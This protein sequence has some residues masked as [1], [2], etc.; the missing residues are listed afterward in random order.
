MRKDMYTGG[1]RGGFIYLR[2]AEYV[3]S[4][5]YKTDIKLPMLYKKCVWFANRLYNVILDNQSESVRGYAGRFVSAG[6]KMSVVESLHKDGG[7]LFDYIVNFKRYDAI[8]NKPF[9]VELLENVIKHPPLYEMLDLSEEVLGFEISNGTVSYINSM[10]NLI[11][12]NTK[13]AFMNNKEL[14]D[15]IKINSYEEVIETSEKLFNELDITSAFKHLSLILYKN[16][17]R[18]FKFINPIQAGEYVM[19]LLEKLNKSGQKFQDVR[20]YSGILDIIS[21]GSLGY[22]ILHPND[23][24]EYLNR[25]KKNEYY[26]FDLDKYRIIRDICG[27][28]D[29]DK[30]V[31]MDIPMNRNLPFYM[32]EKIWSYYENYK[33]PSIQTYDLI[34]HYFEK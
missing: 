8:L 4:G 33:V 7:R 30:Y 29:K 11:S 3:K 6:I 21:K 16:K 24:R 23:V 2:M 9:L 15:S 12:N 27:L 34:K 18:H 20:E 14:D 31:Y 32:Y 10:R 5:S 22:I 26:K 25:S 13:N 1:S 17:F 28:F 19:Y